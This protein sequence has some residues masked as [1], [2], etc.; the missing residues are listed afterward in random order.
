MIKLCSCV[1]VS[2]V[3]FRRKRVMKYGFPCLVSGSSNRTICDTN[4]Q[5]VYESSANQTWIGHR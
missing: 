3:T 5:Y 1:K 2:A 4:L